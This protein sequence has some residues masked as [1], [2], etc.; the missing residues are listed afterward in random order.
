MLDD[1][2]INYFI[3]EIIGVMSLASDRLE[4]KAYIERALERLE[5]RVGTGD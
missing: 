4:P 1:Q 2:T 5:R 3:N